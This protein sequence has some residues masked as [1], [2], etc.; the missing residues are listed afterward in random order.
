[1]QRYTYLLV[2][3]IINT[4]WIEEEC[5]IQIFTT[6]GKD[7]K[8][9]RRDFPGKDLVHRRGTCGLFSYLFIVDWF[10]WV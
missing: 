6:V 9:M 1:V 2:V 7:V 8:D 5:G 4:D 10:S 3:S